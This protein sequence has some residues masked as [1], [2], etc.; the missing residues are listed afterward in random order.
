MSFVFYNSLKPTA[1]KAFD[2]GTGKH[3]AYVVD[4]DYIAAIN[5]ETGR[6]L[7]FVKVIKSGYGPPIKAVTR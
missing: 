2:A 3:G 1:R 7:D 6:T 4:G 5:K